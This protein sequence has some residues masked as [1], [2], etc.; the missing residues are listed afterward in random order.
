[1]K[2]IPDGFHT[3]TS[4]IVVKDSRGAIALYE[5]ALGA[6][7]HDKIED[8]QSKKIVHA[9]LQIGNSMLFLCDENN[10]MGAMAP[11][12]TCTCMSFYLYVENID[13]SHKQAV[14]SGM[15]EL[16]APVDMF[17]GDR[18]STVQDPFGYKWSFATHIKDMSPEEMKKEME[19]QFCKK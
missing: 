15:K 4:C 11:S 18:M 12:P 14:S 9:K 17:W 13:H 3:I 7:V 5:K 1:M 19:K 10:K 6:K 16:Q 8:P 2:K